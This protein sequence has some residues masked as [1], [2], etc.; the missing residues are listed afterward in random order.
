[1]ELRSETLGFGWG[2]ILRANYTYV[3]NKAGV[4]SHQQ[5]SKFKIENSAIIT[6][7]DENR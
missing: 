6:I 5:S 3:A 4:S 2:E 7:N 1:V